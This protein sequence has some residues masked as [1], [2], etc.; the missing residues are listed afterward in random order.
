LFSF[1]TYQGYL[2]ARKRAKLGGYRDQPA[3]EVGNEKGATVLSKHVQNGHPAKGND[4]C[5]GEDGLEQ[6]FPLSEGRCGML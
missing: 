5:F 1:L 3:Y 4:H 2:F 6:S